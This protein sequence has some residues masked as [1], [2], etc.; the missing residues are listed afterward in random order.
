MIKLIVYTKFYG[1]TQFIIE[2]IN[3]EVTIYN[4]NAVYEQKTIYFT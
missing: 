4:F 1:K 2:Q 3:E